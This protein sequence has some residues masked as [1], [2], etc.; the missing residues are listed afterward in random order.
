MKA[1]AI[2]LAA[3]EGTRMNSDMP[4]V[5]H[6]V[7]GVSII[8][9]VVAAAQ[10]AGVER[11]VV[12]TGHKADVVEAL[13]PGLEFARQNEQHGTGHA[14]MCAL[15]AVGELA[16]PVV[17]L[18]GDVPLIR[19]ETISSLVE[20]AASTK[21]AC[22]VLSARFPD[23]TG[24]G[25]IIRDASGQV[26]GITEHKDLPA[27]LLGMDECN[28]GS[29]CFDGAALSAHLH[30]LEASNAQA[31]YYLTDLV[32]LFASE[33]LGVRAVITDD[34]DESHGV[35]SRVQLAEV[36]RVLQR[37]IN[38]RHMLAGVTMIS[39]ESTWIA[40][41]VTLGRDVILEPMTF[42]MGE[43]SV[44]D[45]AHLGPNTRITDSTIGADARVD[46]SILLGADVGVGASVGPVA[47]LRPGAVLAARAKAGTCV[48]IKNSI[49]GENSKVPHLSYIGDA[50]IG[51]G[52][53]VGAGTI[54]CNYDGVAKHRTII[55][56]GVFIGSD[57]MLV[58]PVRIGEGAITGAGSAIARDVPAGAL[59]I[60]RTEQ[61][62]V[63]GFAERRR[64]QTKRDE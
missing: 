24:Y 9:H 52:V 17:I 23:P 22:V 39:P 11:V 57:T 18:A 3:G 41:G 14:V 43:V 49:V 33:G 25:R 61:R 46:S 34:V 26:T 12:V 15:E 35:N 1:T 64:K 54:T 31:E 63:T 21:A 8:E 47:Y 16:G 10:A 13:L 55:E 7:L 60:E 28:V 36:T 53:N 48:E 27:E 5:A 51:S 62:N 40:P 44:G 2:I 29:Y 45:R 19:P 4:K 38:E 56:D 58:A 37:R 42:L 59:G 50:T 32:A 30:R 6:E 20:T